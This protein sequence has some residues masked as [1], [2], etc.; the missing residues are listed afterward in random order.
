MADIS[1][2]NLL[3]Y[4]Q[5]PLELFKQLEQLWLNNNDNAN[6]HV[7][8]GHNEKV[9]ATV[10]EL[11]NT[12]GID[13]CDLAAQALAE[14]FEQHS[15]EYLLRDA[16]PSLS[17][18]MASLICYLQA[19]NSTQF[20]A[21]EGLIKQQPEFSRRLVSKLIELGEPF[22]VDYIPL[23]INNLPSTDIKDAHEELLTLALDDKEPVVQGAI[24]GLG[25]IKYDPKTDQVLMEATVELLEQFLL[26]NNSILSEKA[27]WSLCGLL[28]F[29]EYIQTK[30]LALAKRNDPN[31][32]LKIIRYMSNSPK[33]ID[34][35]Q[36]FADLLMSFAVVSWKNSELSRSLDFLLSHIFINTSLQ[37]IAVQFL[38]AWIERNESID[39]KY[40]IESL[41]GSTLSTLD[42]KT[43]IFNS[44]V[45]RFLNHDHSNVNSAAAAFVNY[46]NL[47]RKKKPQLDQTTIKSLN[48]EELLYVCRKILGYFY[49]AED[50][51]HLFYSILIAKVDDS[52]GSN[53][54]ASIFATF[55]GVEFRDTTLG[56]LQEKLADSSLTQ[57]TRSLITDIVSTIEHNSAPRNGLPVLNELL[58]SKRQSYQVAL[59][60]RKYMDESMEEAEKGSL[61]SMLFSKIH[62]KYGKGSFHHFGNK[63]SEPN[64]LTSHSHSIEFPQSELNNPVKAAFDRMNYR[65]AKKGQ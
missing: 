21:I 15:T 13:V 57:E 22:V 53:L 59:E 48:D 9:T 55:I 32:S 12:H 54:V 33:Y 2:Q 5:E 11:H 37:E 29:G 3:E 43:T 14:G 23:I 26:Q 38:A 6:N 30:V 34:D 45:T 41:L 27:A 62:L 44:I 10:I 46:A 1:E 64:V 28:Y 24:L 61:T 4:R 18:N 63:Y 35:S 16:L 50:F 56:F 40:K 51:L 49:T 65:Q 17:L 36:W 8:V 60:K 19:I 58:I 47:Y 39:D 42:S 25:N 52:E 31:L 7:I 20:T